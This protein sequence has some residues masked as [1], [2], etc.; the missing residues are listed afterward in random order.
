MSGMSSTPTPNSSE[1]R[2]PVSTTWPAVRMTKRSPSPMSKMISAAT[3][4][5]AQPKKT[6]SGR[7]PWARLCRRAASWLGWECLPSTNRALPAASSAQA[8]A[9]V[10]ARRTT[11]PASAAP[12]GA[13]TGPAGW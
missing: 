9:G 2:T 5:S 1:P 4:E 13:V 12:S 3:R 11:P 8:C 7:W 10:E 6:A